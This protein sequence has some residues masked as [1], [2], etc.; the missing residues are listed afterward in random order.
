MKK[1]L[2]LSVLLV[3]AMAVPASAQFLV[4]WSDN[5]DSYALG[6]LTGQGG[7]T[8]STATGVVSCKVVDTQ[9]ES[10]TQ[11]VQ[12][13]I[14]VKSANAKDMR[15]LNATGVTYV[16]GYVKFWVWDPLTGGSTTDTRVGLHSSTGNNSIAKIITAQI[17]DVGTG[18]KVYWMGQWSYSGVFMDGVTAPSGTG[19]YFTAGQ[20]APRLP[21]WNHVYIIWAFDYTMGAGYVEWRVNQV[22]NANLILNFNST[23]GRWANTKDVAGVYIGAYN[24]AS[25]TPGWIDSAEFHANPVPEPASL[26]VLGSGLV[27]LAGLIRRRR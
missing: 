11:S 14:S 21:G 5:F 19:Y 27:G 23:S 10:G 20:P 1:V 22:D 24:S 3:I 4:N 17:T 15:P 7:W 13:V 26:L 9:A 6:D 8:T 2:V 18:S 25:A 16:N 12:Q